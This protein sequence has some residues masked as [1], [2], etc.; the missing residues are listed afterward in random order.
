MPALISDFS[1]TG[2]AVRLSFI[3]ILPKHLLINF[4]VSGTGYNT[5]YRNMGETENKGFEI[6]L[7]GVIAD[8]K[9]FRAQPGLQYRV[10]PE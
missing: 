8:K 5:Q 10:Q 6:A 4:P 3:S 1:E 9:N 2:L 7:N